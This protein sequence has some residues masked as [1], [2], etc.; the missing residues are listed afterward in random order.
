MN[1]KFPRLELELDDAHPDL[2]PVLEDFEEWCGERG[3][4][5]PVVTSVKRT[6]AENA[7]L[8]EASPDSW[9][10]VGCA[11]DVRA[12]NLTPEQQ[13]EALV[14]FQRRCPRPEWEVLLH[15]KGQNIHFH[16]G[17]KHQGWRLSYGQTPEVA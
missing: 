17:R 13:R 5:E 2:R 14:W 7:R 1:F 6:P 16:V 11:V 3:R 9:H 12:N 10:L 8:P 4:P 15:G